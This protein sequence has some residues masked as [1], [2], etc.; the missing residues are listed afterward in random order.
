MKFS[1]KHFWV[2]FN[3]CRFG[4]AAEPPVLIVEPAEFEADESGRC[5]IARATRVTLRISL[6]YLDSGFSYLWNS[7]GELT[8]LRDEAYQTPGL[9]VFSPCTPDGDEHGDGCFQCSGAKLLPGAGY[10][11]VPGTEGGY[12]L[13]FELA[14]AAGSPYMNLR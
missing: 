13:E 14:P 11:A 8:G 9:L 10:R 7:R 12:R 1:L 6:K 5:E 4:L 3:D 2:D